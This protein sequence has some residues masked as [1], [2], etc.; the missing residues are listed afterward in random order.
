MT[1]GERACAWVLLIAVAVGVYFL[2]KRGRPIALY[3][4]TYH[5]P[6]GYKTIR[7]EDV[8]RHRGSVD[9]ID[10]VTKERLTLYGDVTVKNLPIEY[11]PWW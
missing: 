7:S 9:V 1:N 6:N 2:G 3:E 8:W 11:D 4:V 5:T 10:P